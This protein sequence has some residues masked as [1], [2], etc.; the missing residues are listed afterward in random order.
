MSQENVEVVRQALRAFNEEG[1]D[2]ATAFYDYADGM[3]VAGMARVVRGSASAGSGPTNP[4]RQRIGR[5]RD[6]KAVVRA[7]LPHPRL[8]GHQAI[9]CAN[10]RLDP[11]SLR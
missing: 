3:R 6:A 11:P 4:L 7:D 9:G 10:H 1:A 8:Q 5:M 2:T